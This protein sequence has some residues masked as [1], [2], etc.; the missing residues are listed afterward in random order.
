LDWLIIYTIYALVMATQGW[1]VYT[2]ARFIRRRSGG[3]HWQSK[4]L[5]MIASYIGWTVLTLGG[6]IML[7]VV[8]G[9]ME[10]LA[11][12]AFL[13]FTATIATLIYLGAWLVRKPKAL[14]TD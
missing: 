7:G 4:V 6:V 2:T 11:L 8:G 3:Q 9:L 5:A 1:V 10:G 13:W 14:Q 12:V